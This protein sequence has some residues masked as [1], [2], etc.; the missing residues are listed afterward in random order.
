MNAN[1]HF[2]ALR[3]QARQRRDKEIAH[4]RA[5]YQANLSQIAELEQRLLGRI[6][7]KQMKLSAA[8]EHVIPRDEP[9]TVPDLMHSLEGLDPSRVW[10]KTSVHRHVTQLREL[11]LVRRVK[12]AKVN[13]PASYVR[14]EGPGKPEPAI[15][16]KTLRQVLVETVKRPMFIAEVV[17]AVQEAGYKTTMIPA[18]LRTHVIRELK[19]AGFREVGGKWAT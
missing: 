18:N 19:S 3:T 1:A 7:P 16:D 10:R 14:C 11:G 13:E 9:F 6:S 12:R 2:A 17:M 15:R 8:V 5:E 4:A